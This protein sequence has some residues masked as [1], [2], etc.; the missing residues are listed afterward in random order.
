MSLPAATREKIKDR[1]DKLITE[2]K[3]L[4]QDARTIPAEYDRSETTGRQ[5]ETRAQRTVIDWPRFVVWRTKAASLLTYVLPRK[6]VHAAHAAAI[7][8]LEA[9]KGY[10]E[11]ILS[12]LAGVKDDLEAGFLGNLS[13]QIES[14][15]AADYMSQAES[16][17]SGASNGR[18]N[19]I[20]A[21]VLAGA[22][23]EKT[24][25][26]LC[27][28]CEPPVPVLNGK[29]DPKTL[30]PLIEDLKK[31][32][33][34]SELKAKQLRAWADIRNQAAHGHFDAVSP[35][36]VAQM[37]AGVSAFLADYMR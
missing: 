25:R 30:G 22:V 28:R 23:L 16:L 17:L 10:V 8:S 24:L 4:L 21:A 3:G 19:H 15:V 14:D 37:V 33:L 18:H 9:T 7:P 6:H 32:E 29:G 34:F 26:G 20:P 2:G 12:M 27:E 13:V 36:D 5:Y 1:F 35:G 31:A 11:F